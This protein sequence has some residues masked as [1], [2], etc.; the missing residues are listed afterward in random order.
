MCMVPFWLVMV[1][2]SIGPTSGLAP[3]AGMIVVAL[4]VNSL[5]GI[6]SGR[7]RPDESGFPSLALMNCTPV[8]WLF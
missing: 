6:G 1:F 2:P 4:M 7:F 3:M 8:A 5:F